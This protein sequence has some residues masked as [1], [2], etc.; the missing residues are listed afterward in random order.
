MP[1]G[2]LRISSLLLTADATER[3]VCLGLDPCSLVAPLGDEA[4]DAEVRLDRIQIAPT[5]AATSPTPPNILPAD[6]ECEQL[7]TGGNDDE[8][9]LEGLL[10]NN[11]SESEHCALSEAIS[12]RVCPAVAGA[13]VLSE[14][15]AVNPSLDDFA[16]HL[17]ARRHLTCPN[18]LN[19]HF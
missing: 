5:T 9:C 11:H 6:M 19:V 12:T 1:I 2:N 10:H 8:R 14:F 15:F 17:Q 13:A 7:G 3:S 4:G 18:M 16:D